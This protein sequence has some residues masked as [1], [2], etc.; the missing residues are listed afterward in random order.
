ML[1]KNSLLNQ[2]GLS[3]N[4][5]V[6]GCNPSFPSLLGNMLPALDQNHQSDNFSGQLKMIFEARNEFLKAE[7]SAK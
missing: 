7:S 5:I 4:Q 3:P 2:E 1:Q 6:Y